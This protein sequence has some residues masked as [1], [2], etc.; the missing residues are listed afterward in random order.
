MTKLKSFFSNIVYLLKKKV[1]TVWLISYI[2]I[3][4]IPITMSTFVS[5][6]AL[7]I[8]FDQS[9][10]LAYEI[11]ARRQDDVNTL[12]AECDRVFENL[13]LNDEIQNILS[14]PYG[15]SVSAM[16]GYRIK[17]EVSTLPVNQ[18]A[19]DDIWVVFNNTSFVASTMRT[20]SCE[21]F[22]SV[23]NG[24]IFTS[25]QIENGIFE[26]NYKGQLFKTPDSICYLKTI[27]YIGGSESYATLVVSIVPGYMN[28]YESLYNDKGTF[29]LINKENEL[30]YS[31]KEVTR[32][33]V[34]DI[35]SSGES[36]EFFSGKEKFL[37]YESTDLNI[38]HI[39]TLPYDTILDKSQS[40]SMLV[41][42]TT[43]ITIL[44]GILSIRYFVKRNLRPINEIMKL[45]GG[46]KGIETN[47]Y[48]IIMDNLKLK[49]QDAWEMSNKI[50]AFK[51]LVMQ[52]V[53]EQ[54]LVN[55]SLNENV[56][57][58]VGIDF[59]NPYFY[60][61]LVDI[62]NLGDF[63]DLEN[64]NSFD[65]AQ[66]LSFVAMSN[67]FSETLS[68]LGKA[69]SGKIDETI[70]IILNTDKTDYDI[71]F[72]HVENAYTM[73]QKYLD[74]TA[75]IIIS[76]PA[77]G[78]SELPL[79]YQDG[80][81]RLEYSSIMETTGINSPTAGEF[82]P[83]SLQADRTDI[84]VSQILSGDQNAAMA[85]INTVIKENV[86]SHTHSSKYNLANMLMMAL[87]KLSEYDKTILEKAFACDDILKII[88]TAQKL[89]DVTH[90]L[91]AFISELC[92][93]ASYIKIESDSTEKQV[94][95]YINENFS[96]PDINVKIIADTFRITPSYLSAKFKQ[97]YGIGIL[98]FINTV[99]INHAKELLSTTELSIEAIYSQCG[100]ISKAT[101]LRQF[102]KICGVTPTIYRE[103]R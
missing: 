88:M 84:F 71:I 103:V 36:R 15:S 45:V 39:Y 69:Y 13:Y 9:E 32:P 14:K 27:R 18:D 68:P 94:Y 56:S 26:K 17:A 77:H 81:N 16:E 29:L 31:N 101:F 89:S 91:E 66:Q 61:I 6:R 95:D 12:W 80:L 8:L 28:K 53:L 78:A 38:R 59:D 19:I 79:V 7:N 96:N 20:M 92:S 82:V 22:F 44:L 100:Y 34:E 75:T 55:G 1:S 3:F 35:I 11:I 72:S 51:P 47:E 74:V 102:K 70:I 87:G 4:L 2:V 43:V 49:N 30:I 48:N 10:M 41:I 23:E 46:N 86:L 40:L 83:S 37:K 85:T 73:A 97:K 64:E 76:E 54:L 60:V 52:N 98:E 67:I 99:R 24:S 58:Q 25:E 57:Q 50:N 62:N 63:Q 21:E 90:K 93:I 33:F 5:S 65:E 42:I